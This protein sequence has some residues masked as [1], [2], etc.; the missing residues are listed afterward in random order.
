M[1]PGVN[2]DSP[3]FSPDNKTE[4]QS[5]LRRIF[6]G[7]FSLFLVHPGRFILIVDTMGNQGHYM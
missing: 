4:S 1:S 5:Q 3:L 7:L 2:A 6:K